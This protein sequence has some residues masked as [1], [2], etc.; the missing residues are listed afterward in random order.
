MLL[1]FDLSRALGGMISADV[2]VM[3]H[4]HCVGLGVRHSDWFDESEVELNS[5]VPCLV[6]TSASTASPDISRK[7]RSLTRSTTD[8]VG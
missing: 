8:E 7:I 2:I 1:L 3:K 4:L 6:I 5:Q